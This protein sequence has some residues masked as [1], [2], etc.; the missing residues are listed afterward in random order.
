MTT[1]QAT[2]ALLNVSGSH[3]GGKKRKAEATQPTAPPFPASHYALTL[4]QMETMGYPLP[5]LDEATGQMRAP[6]G[7]VATPPGKI[8]VGY[9]YPSLG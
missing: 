2:S 4:A 5:V 3:G 6:E 9:I 8:T 1:G 7:F